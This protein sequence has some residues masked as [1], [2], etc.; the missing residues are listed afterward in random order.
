MGWEANKKAKSSDLY[1]KSVGE[2]TSNENQVI[3]PFQWERNADRSLITVKCKNGYT[4]DSS[5][6]TLSGSE[7]K[8]AH[9]Q[10]LRAYNAGSGGVSAGINTNPFNTEVSNEIEGCSL[11]TTTHEFTIPAGK[12]LIDASLE[13]FYVNGFNTRLYNVTDG[14]VAL[15][16]TVGYAGCASPYPHTFATLKG[17]IEIASAKVYRLEVYCQTARA[18]DAF[19]WVSSSRGTD[20]AAYSDI[21]ITDIESIKGAKGD[22]GEPGTSGADAQNYLP[23]I[24]IPTL[25]FTSVIPDWALDCTDGATG[26]TFADYPELDN[27]IF[28]QFLAD[29]T[30]FNSADN[31]TTFDMPDLQGMFGRLAGTNGIYGAGIH[32]GGAV[33]DYTA[34]QFQNHAHNHRHSMG[35]STDDNYHGSAYPRTSNDYSSTNYTNYTAANPSSGNYGSET[36]PASFS[37]TLIVRFE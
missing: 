33:G 34:H 10:N 7:I 31:T 26:Y 14:A 5:C 32:I 1:P 18:S 37:N 27:E 36:R 35:V 17:V 8:V 20:D 23:P 24:G 22:K 21:I 13:L 30:D 12:F 4:L 3:Q 28:R 11:N 15:R 25:W 29:F 16:G 19:G 6:I 9:F 2:D